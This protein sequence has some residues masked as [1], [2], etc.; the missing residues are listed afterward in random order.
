[1]RPFITR[2]RQLPDPAL[3]VVLQAKLDIARRSRLGRNLTEAAH[4]GNVAPGRPEADVIQ[5]VEEFGPE[6]EIMLFAHME[7]LTDRH[8]HVE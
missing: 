5:R 1:M 4:R 8:V 2:K 7:L 3:K 6:V